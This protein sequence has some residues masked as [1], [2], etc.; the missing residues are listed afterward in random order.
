MN[1]GWNWIKFYHLTSNLLPRYVAKFGRLFFSL[2]MYFYWELLTSLR[3]FT[4]APA[5]DLAEHI[6]TS[7][8][9]LLTSGMHD[10]KH[11]WWLRANILNTCCKLVCVNV[12]HSY[13]FQ[14]HLLWI[15][16]SAS[17]LHWLTKIAQ[18]KFRKVVRQ[19]NWGE[20]VYFIRSFSQFVDATVKE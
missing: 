1:C 3:Y 9:H 6:T 13:T 5:K 11:A 12:K 4:A 2:L 19:E 16:D 10:L 14:I 15:N 7:S 17:L 18:F 8:T 20:V